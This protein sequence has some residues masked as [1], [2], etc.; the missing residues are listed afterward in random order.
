MSL[1]EKIEIAEQIPSQFADAIVTAHILSHSFL[2][3]FCGLMA[4]GLTAVLVRLVFYHDRLIED[5][6]WAV[7][8]LGIAW[9]ALVYSCAVDTVEVITGIKAPEVVLIQYVEKYDDT[10]H[11]DE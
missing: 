11:V 4:L 8:L 6:T 2:A 7:L 5:D 3:I 9:A 1:F 10:P